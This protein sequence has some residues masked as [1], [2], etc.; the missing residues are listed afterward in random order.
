MPRRVQRNF[1]SS[2]Q[3]EDSGVDPF[4]EQPN[5]DFVIPDSVDLSDDEEPSPSQYRVERELEDAD[6]PVDDEEEEEALINSDEE[7]LQETDPRSASTGSSKVSSAEAVY[8]KFINMG[9]QFVADLEDQR[10]QDLM[11][12]K[13]ARKYLNFDDVRP[14]RG[15]QLQFTPPR[16]T[17]DLIP[18]S[19]EESSMRSESSRST[20]IRLQEKFKIVECKKF[21]DMS[22]ADIDAWIENVAHADM[23]RAGNYEDLKTRAKS[24]GGFVQAHVSR[25]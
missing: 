10:K 11:A 1:T 25:L 9:R 23:L 3:S 2:S 22:R 24:I 17:R 16:K 18:E 6:E 20:R 19:D 15:Q 21:C 13:A 14:P 12:R 7:H 5:K 8:T 4:A